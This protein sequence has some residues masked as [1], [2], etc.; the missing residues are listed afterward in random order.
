[1]RLLGGDKPISASEL[2]L[3]KTSGVRGYANQF[4]TPEA[5]VNRIAQF[6]AR[7]IPMSEMEGWPQTIMKT[8]L[9][10]VNAFVRKYARPERQ[11]LLMV[12]DRDKI[13]PGIRA[14][15]LG[16]IVVL[17]RRGMPVQ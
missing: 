8:S 12:G 5:L 2:E 9:E 15:D 11:M 16:E 3:A 6:W 17:D 10:S 13:E 4:E 7:G 1:L 14:L